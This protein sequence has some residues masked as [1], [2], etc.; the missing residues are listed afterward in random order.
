M[1]TAT[2]TWY[3]PKAFCPRL[4]S[5]SMR[6]DT[7]GSPG[8]AKGSLSTI[9]HESCSPATSTP[10]QK[11][12]VARSTAWGVARKVSSSCAFGASPWMRRG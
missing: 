11:D 2:G 6:A 3:S 8:E 1:S 5:R 4:R 7:T 9:T 10:C 12:V